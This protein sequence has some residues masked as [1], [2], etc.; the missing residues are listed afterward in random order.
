MDRQFVDGF[1]FKT[2]RQGAPDY[3]IG[4]VS[5]KVDEFVK[6]AEKNVNGGGYVNIDVK[7]S[8]KGNAYGELNTWKAKEKKE[9]PP[10]EIYEEQ[11]GVDVK[12]IPF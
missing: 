3:V 5:I 12:S 4:S 8:K 11:P 10:E 9:E 1:F 2:P 6:L 7:I